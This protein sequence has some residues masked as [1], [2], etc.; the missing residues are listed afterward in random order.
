MSPRGG[1]GGRGVEGGG[2]GTGSEQI[3]REKEKALHYREGGEQVRVMDE[4]GG[5]EG[6]GCAEVRKAASAGT[7]H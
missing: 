7:S 1:K 2:G 4:L 6:R 3:D 5:T